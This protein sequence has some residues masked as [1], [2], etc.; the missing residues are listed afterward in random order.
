MDSFVPTEASDKKFE[1]VTGAWYKRARE[2]QLSHYRAAEMYTRA[3]RWLAIPSVVLSAVTGTALFLSLQEEM[4]GTSIRVVAGLLSILSAVLTALHSFLGLGDRAEQHRSSARL[5]GSIRR[6][7]ERHQA[8]Q[9]TDDEQRS[10]ILDDLRERLDRAA[11]LA[12]EVPASA[13]KRAQ[14]DI[15]HSDRPGGFRFGTD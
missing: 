6:E 2:A 10:A 12:P 1:E 7:V 5:Y 11:E 8:F 4:A 3:G 14:T 13:W 9:P 15:E